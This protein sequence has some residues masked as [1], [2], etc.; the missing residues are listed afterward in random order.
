MQRVLKTHGWPCGLISNCNFG[1]SYSFFEHVYSFYTDA[2]IIHWS[3]QLYHTCISH[4]SIGSSFCHCSV[5]PREPII[6]G[7]ASCVPY[8]CIYLPFRAV[9]YA[10]QSGCMVLWSML[11]PIL[12]WCRT[13]V[14]WINSINWLHL[15]AQAYTKYYITCT[16][17]LC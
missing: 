7:F 10:T 17:K 13:V 3:S 5:W 2:P 9:G 16:Y 8:M 6:F 15:T 12:N 1:V 14:S 11:E 4:T